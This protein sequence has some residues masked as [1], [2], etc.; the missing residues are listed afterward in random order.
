MFEK[1]DRHYMDQ[2]FS[3]YVK[4]GKA[5]SSEKRIEILHRLIHGSKTVEQLARISDMTV[6]NTSRH[7]QVLKEANL[8]NSFKD[9]KYIVYSISSDRIEHILNDI[10]LLSEEQSP[11]LRYIEAEFDQ[12]DPFIKTLSVKEAIVLAD[13][14]EVQLI[15][16]RIPKEFSLDHIQDAINIPYHQLENNID[17][18]SKDIPIILYCRGRF[19]PYANQ[20][21]AYLN[22][23]GFE[24][25]S[26]NMTH[27]EWQREML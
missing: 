15:D 14:K 2:V 4:I 19:C 27:F 6:A 23:L 10:H 17:C 24:A 16:L 8:V 26:V 18:I 25:Y 22:K 11:K 13:Q 7:L 21:S 1:N 9:G 3:E 12:S 5:I 20:A